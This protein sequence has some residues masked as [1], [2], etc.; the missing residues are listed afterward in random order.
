MDYTLNLLEYILYDFF[1]P[2]I[3]LNKLI[4]GVILDVF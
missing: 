1:I 3:S 4:S 2:D